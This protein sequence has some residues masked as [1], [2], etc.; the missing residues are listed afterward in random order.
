VNPAALVPTSAAGR[1]ALVFLTGLGL[2]LALFLLGFQLGRH[3]ERTR[4]L[5]EVVGATVE[6]AA[7]LNQQLEATGAAV[8]DLKAQAGGR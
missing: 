1:F 4:E 8:G 6:A 3:V 7:A 5:A 2:G